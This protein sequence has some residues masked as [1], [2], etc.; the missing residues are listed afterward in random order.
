MSSSSGELQLQQLT[1]LN[2]LSACRSMDVILDLSVTRDCLYNL[3]ESNESDQRGDGQGLGTEGRGDSLE[4][5]EDDDEQEDEDEW[6]KKGDLNLV[7]PSSVSGIFGWMGLGSASASPVPPL[8]TSS[9][10]SGGT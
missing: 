7:A 10:K 8:T 9:E 5:Y 2:I 6:G 1:T 3:K 4:D